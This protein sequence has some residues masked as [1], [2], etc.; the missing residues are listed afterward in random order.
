MGVRLV[1]IVEQ[2]RKGSRS[3]PAADLARL[4]LRVG[5]PL[6]RNA[7]FLPDDEELVRRARRIADEILASDAP[8]A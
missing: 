8:D 7:A 5:K 2:V 3:L 1:Q 4:N 6:S